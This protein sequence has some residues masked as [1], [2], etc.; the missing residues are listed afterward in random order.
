ME[1]APVETSGKPAN[2]ILFCQI[3]VGLKHDYVT[4]PFLVPVGS[5]FISK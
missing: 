5:V 4:A 2:R 1:N 3:T